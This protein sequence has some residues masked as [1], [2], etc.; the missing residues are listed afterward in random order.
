[1]GD[2]AKEVMW[3]D[4]EDEVGN[5]LDGFPRAAGRQVLRRVRQHAVLALLRWVA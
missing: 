5:L 3:M 1:M 2:G 4:E